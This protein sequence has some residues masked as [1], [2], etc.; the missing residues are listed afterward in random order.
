MSKRTKTRVLSLSTWRDEEA[1]IRWRTQR[2]GEVTADTAPP[3]GVA[4]V[5]Q[6]FDTTE[7]GQAKVAV[8]SGGEA[9]RGKAEDPRCG[10]AAPADGRSLNGAEGQQCGAAP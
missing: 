5:E 8:L 10:G 3:G 2:V 4:V 1:V 6:R 7:T 9:G